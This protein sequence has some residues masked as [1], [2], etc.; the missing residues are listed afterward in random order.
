MLPSSL[1]SGILPWGLH[2]DHS[3][4]FGFPICFKPKPPALCHS[5][6]EGSDLQE[7]PGRVEQG[8]GWLLPPLPWGF[9]ASGERRVGAGFG[10]EVGMEGAVPLEEQPPPPL[11]SCPQSPWG[12]AAAA[13]GCSQEAPGAEEQLLASPPPP[14]ALPS[15]S[16]R[17]V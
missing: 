7:A 14:S 11:A 10:S 2:G 3:A 8:A 15:L 9:F 13:R 4:G 16:S 6:Q 5:H 1:I 17:S 12:G